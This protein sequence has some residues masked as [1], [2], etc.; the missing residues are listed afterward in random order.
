MLVTLVLSEMSAEEYI[1]EDDAELNETDLDLLHADLV[2]GENLS[3]RVIW[4]NASVKERDGTIGDTYHSEARSDASHRKASIS[5]RTAAN[6]F[7]RIR[8]IVRCRPLLES[9]SNQSAERLKVEDDCVIIRHP[10]SGEGKR[11]AFDRVMPQEAAQHDVFGEV[12]PMID[13]VLNGF[14]ATVFAYG[15][16]GSG[17]TYT[18]DGLTYHMQKQGGNL[19]PT[20]DA[21]TPVEQHGVLLRVIQMIFDRA[22]ARCRENTD[23]DTGEPKDGCP[24]FDFKCS[25]LQIYNEKITDLLRST[26]DRKVASPSDKEGLQLRWQKGDVFRP[27]NLFLCECDAPSKMR[28]AFFRGVKEKVVASHLLNTQSSRSHSIFTIYVTRRDAKSGDILSRSEFSLV[29]LAGSEKLKA[30]TTNS[31]SRIA[32]E[33][34]EINT[35]LLALGKVIIALANS[36]GKKAVHIPYRESKLTKLLKHSIG[37]NSLTTMIACISPCDA[38]ID[39][40]VATMLYAGRA[41]HIENAPKVNEDPNYAIIRLLREEIRQ[42]KEE[43]QYYRV[44]ASNGVEKS[45]RQVLSQSEGSSALQHHQP[46]HPAS[47]EEKSELADSLLSACEMLKQ[48]ITVNG[49]LRDAYD[50][51][52]SERE[53][54]ASKE[55]HLNAEN[56]AL[57]E[58]IEMLESIVLNDEFMNTTKGS[59]AGR[60]ASD[61]VSDGDSDDEDDEERGVDEKVGREEKHSPASAASPVM[62]SARTVEPWAASASSFGKSPSDANMSSI[63]EISTLP[64]FDTH[65]QTDVRRKQ[66]AIPPQRAAEQLDSI[67]GNSDVP[68]DKVRMH[69]PPQSMRGNSQRKA[70]PRV[71]TEP[72]RA[73]PPSGKRIAKET[74]AIYT[75]KVA[76]RNG[77]SGRK[78]TSQRKKKLASRLQEYDQRYRQPRQNPTYSDFYG[79]AQPRSTAQNKSNVAIAEM[80]VVLKKLP[81]HMTA[82]V[83]P[84]SLKLSGN[85]GDLNFVGSRGDI[86]DLQQKRMDR[87]EKL[88]SLLQRN[89]ELNM[90]VHS[91]A[92]GKPLPSR[93][94]PSRR[95]ASSG[96][97][98]SRNHSEARR[99]PRSSIGS[100]SQLAAPYSASSRDER[101]NLFSSTLPP[102][103]TYREKEIND[104]N[105]KLRQILREENRRREA[106]DRQHPYSG[107]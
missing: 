41:K 76:P 12:M 105:S 63:G 100:N 54:N 84:S 106:S 53:V 81:S 18:M 8:V 9:E 35:S 15:Q 3:Q 11:F 96:A 44:L 61:G 23:S 59:G 85:F 2:H 82:E 67:W 49:Q 97:I 40:S 62:V 26:T 87:E 4:K 68:E 58:R 5:R 46:E 14:H 88:R 65:F 92:T 47:L 75:A 6:A 94:E 69:E 89:M 101:P 60:A 83:V 42:L 52:K 48:I 103:T 21:N 72:A 34:I 50:V 80:D 45:E 32:K 43:L 51:L 93:F 38:Y 10:V 36:R 31:K 57:R 30:I 24:S 25:F 39:E 95:P 99:K 86:A 28:D 56:L 74:E 17:K 78:K 13:H 70:A 37:G 102:P 19:V 20:P 1:A 79:R 98:P 64:P 27:Q 107:R 90:L 7:G 73:A 16:T 104:Y 29:D 91:E 77:N 33:S 66:R 55:M 71:F 22:A